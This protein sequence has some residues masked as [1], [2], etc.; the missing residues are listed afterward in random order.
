MAMR[1]VDMR[2]NSEERTGI[3]T[4]HLVS[5][6]ALI[7]LAQGIPAD[8]AAAELDLSPDTIGGRVGTNVGDD[9][10]SVLHRYDVQAQWALP[11]R[12]RLQGV[13]LNPLVEATAGL[14]HNNYAS[15][16]VGSVTAGA[17]LT[18]GT[19]GFYLSATAGL[20]LVSDYRLGP[21]DFG[22]PLQG[23]FGASLGFRISKRLSLGYRYDHFSDAGLYGADNRGVDMHMLE[24]RYGLGGH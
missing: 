4:S 2:V 11:W 24:L 12:W 6:L 17:D 9:A 1:Y 20:L 16:L 3:R 18:A 15:A 23:A 22:G 5:L 19:T 7:T 10:R 13:T 21:E 14:L 8:L